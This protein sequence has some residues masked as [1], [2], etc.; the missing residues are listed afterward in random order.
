[1]KRGMKHAGM[2]GGGQTRVSHAY[3]APRE[4]V[5]H[6]RPLLHIA[7]TRGGG[8]TQYQQTQRHMLSSLGTTKSRRTLAKEKEN[9]C[10]YILQMIHHILLLL[11]ERRKDSSTRRTACYYYYPQTA[12]CLSTLT[13]LHLKDS[14][15][16]QA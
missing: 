15:L 6:G 3:T 12:V 13:L 1:M 16:V 8:D 10:I 5:F 14:R 7:N 9:T 4:H 11:E 2:G